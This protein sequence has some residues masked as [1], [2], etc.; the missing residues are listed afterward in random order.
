M[1]VH[2]GTLAGSASLNGSP[3]P[4]LFG[5]RYPVSRVL[6]NSSFGFYVSY[7]WGKTGR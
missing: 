4:A 5:N 7:A 3:P 6:I 2:T 1:N